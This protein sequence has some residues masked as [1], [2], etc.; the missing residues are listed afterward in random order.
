[1]I[2]YVQVLSILPVGPLVAHGSTPWG[3]DA[4]TSGALV[5]PRSDTGP[6]KSRN[7][8]F[9]QLS[10]NARSPAGKTGLQG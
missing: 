4:P 3:S 10:A 8:G 9:G 2:T 6:A 5:W 7:H 1:M